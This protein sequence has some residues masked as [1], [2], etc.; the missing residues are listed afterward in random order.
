MV[1]TARRE[2]RWPDLF[3]GWLGQFPTVRYFLVATLTH[4]ARSWFTLSGR[5]ATAGACPCTQR[6]TLAATPLAWHGGDHGVD[7]DK[8]TVREEREKR[9][10]EGHR[11]G[12]EVS[13]C[14]RLPSLA[15]RWSGARH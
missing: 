11:G 15:P 1:E 14:H 7:V 13:S 6:G 10:K 2:R 4:H 8:L 3:I 5:F 9:R 12:L